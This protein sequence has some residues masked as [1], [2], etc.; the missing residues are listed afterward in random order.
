MEFGKSQEITRE[1]LS[2]LVSEIVVISSR[3]IQIVFSFEDE[4]RSL[5]TVVE[6]ESSEC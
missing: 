3:E 5:C 2:L 6:E 4:F 1:L